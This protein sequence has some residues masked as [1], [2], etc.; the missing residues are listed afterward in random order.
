MSAYVTRTSLIDSF[1]Q[2]RK[3][4]KSETFIFIAAYN[5]WSNSFP[6]STSQIGKSVS[7][8]LTH[9]V[10]PPFF[11]AS[12]HIHYHDR[13]W[14]TRLVHLN[15]VTDI[16]QPF[17]S[18]VR[19]KK[20]CFAEQ[21]MIAGL[22]CCFDQRVTTR[23]STRTTSFSTIVSFRCC[24]IRRPLYGYLGKTLYLFHLPSL[25]QRILIWRITHGYLIFLMILFGDLAK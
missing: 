4:E 17:P 7:D 6:S 3:F 1:G 5:L 16:F 12:C 8:I 14:R 25:S 23:S 15:T 9:W 20:N 18:A 19:R 22:L 21:G 2:F 11:F 10:F 24:I 13:C